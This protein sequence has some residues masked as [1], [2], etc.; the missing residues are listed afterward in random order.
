MND[1]WE[2]LLFK[3]RGFGAKVENIKLYKG[4][5]G[6]GLF[7]INRNEK[8][9]IHIPSSLFIN[10]D[11]LDYSNNKVFIKRKNS[12]NND[13]VDFLNF[14]LNEFSLNN[15][16]K[17]NLNIFR[18]DLNLLNKS[19][20]NI[21][22]DYL[23]F[24]LEK[25]EKK[26]DEYLFNSYLS[27]RTFKFNNSKIFIPFFELINHD[28]SSLPYIFNKNGITS[29]NYDPF[30]GE[31]T[32]SYGLNQSSLKSFLQYHFF[33]KKKNVFSLPFAI[34]LKNSDFK[35]VCNGKD[36]NLKKII[37]LKKEQNKLIIEGFPITNSENKDLPF[38]YFLKIKKSIERYNDIP[39]NLF[40][41]IINYNLLLRKK[42]FQE[43][44][45]VNNQTTKNFSKALEYEINL[46][47]SNTIN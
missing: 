1:K 39:N 20:K 5:K 43:L 44:K 45:Y 4:D 7:S 2:F 23:F 10:E 8:S 6:R 3:L 36:I 17:K 18:E 16:I 24:D 32:I 29:P 38:E 40:K 12:Y 46:I 14:Y 34:D 11:N 33:T 41:I 13:I 28:N 42:I 25:I 30:E 22:K 9:L 15:E 21:L 27:S 35:F 31:L 37:S 26:V 19:T 47:T